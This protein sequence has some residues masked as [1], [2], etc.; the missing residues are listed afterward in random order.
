MSET[1]FLDGGSSYDYEVAGLQVRIAII[2]ALKG[3]FMYKLGIN[4]IPVE[5]WSY[6]PSC[7][8]V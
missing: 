3:G 4:G 6:D 1:K 5:D 8:T 7:L 2:D